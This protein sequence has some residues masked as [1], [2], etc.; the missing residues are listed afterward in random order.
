VPDEGGEEPVVL[1]Q[2]FHRLAEK[3][4]YRASAELE[5]V[6]TE[7][8]EDRADN[9]SGCCSPDVLVIQISAG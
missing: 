3:G 2:E 9:E 8:D 5:S 4:T 1:G 7:A 6:R